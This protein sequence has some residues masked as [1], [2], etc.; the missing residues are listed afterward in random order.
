[1][2]YL[3]KITEFF[4]SLVKV[5][6]PIVSVSILLGV[7]FGPDTVF[8]GAVYTNIAN[9]L[10]LLGEDGLLALVSIVIILTFLKK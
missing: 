2:E 6:L 8:V 5:L 7:I 10:S 3:S 1:M 9:I 4:N